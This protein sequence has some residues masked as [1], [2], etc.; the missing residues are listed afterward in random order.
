M[1]A[2]RL[3][4]RSRHDRRVRLLRAAGNITGIVGAGGFLAG[5]FG[6]RLEVAAAGAVAMVAGEGAHKLADRIET[7]TTNKQ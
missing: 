3:E 5:G 2:E 7:H 4:L 1:A 6:S